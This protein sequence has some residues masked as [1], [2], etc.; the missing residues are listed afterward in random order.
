MLVLSGRPRWRDMFASLK[1][2]NYRLYASGQIVS[3]TAQGMQRIAQDWIVLQL[4]GNVADVGITVALQF[5]PMLVFGLYGGVIADRYPKRRILQ[6]TQTMMALLAATM[7]ALIFTGS[8]QVWMIWC[9]ALLGGFATLIDNPARQSFVSEVVG[10]ALLRNAL[11][12][13]SSTFQLGAL[14]GPAVG[15]ILLSAVGGGWSF[16]INALACL[17][18]VFALGRLDGSRLLPA[19]KAPRRKGQL[20]EGLEYAARKDEILFTLIVLTSV[21]LFVYTMP[22]LLTAFAD[23]VY[24]VGSSG[25]GIFNALVALGAL[26]GALLSNLRASVSLRTVIVGAVILGFV[27]ALAGLAPQLG[28]FAV[29]LV[30]AGMSQLL[31]F[32]ASNSLVQ[33]STNIAIRGRVMG[34]FVL[35]QLGGQSIGG[36]L[37]GWIV[38][39]FGPHVGMTVSGTMPLLTALVAGVVL[40]K[41]RGQTVSGAARRLVQRHV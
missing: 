34:V 28:I 30:G 40:V 7:A 15:G 37:M 10:P 11:S 13:N 17:G 2:P 41:R 9:I 35:I 19:P 5:A 23:H 21:A 1:V 16:A 14:I 27:Q 3:T 20:R 33:M 25:Y 18:T 8:I 36:P 32:I 22:V 29:L 31:Y 4:S 38:D 39:N 24:D 12:L 26:S 6:V